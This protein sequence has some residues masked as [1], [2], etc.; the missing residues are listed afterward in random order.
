MIIKMIFEKNLNRLIRVP[1]V[2]QEPESGRMKTTARKKGIRADAESLLGVLIKL[3]KQLNS[4][5]T[6]L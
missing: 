4:I 6:S 2:P 1:G 3:N 5:F